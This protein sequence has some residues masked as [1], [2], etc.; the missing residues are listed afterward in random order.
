MTAP[1]F[2]AEQFD[3]IPSY[4]EDILWSPSAPNVSIE[5][6]KPEDLER[7]VTRLEQMIPRLVEVI[8]NSGRKTAD[9][10][11]DLIEINQR[12]TYRNL[13]TNGDF[14][15]PKWSGLGVPPGWTAAGGATITKNSSV[16]VGS[17]GCSAFMGAVG[18]NIGMYQDIPIAAGR[19]Y[20]LDLKWRAPTA[21]NKPRVRVLTDGAT[22]VDFTM[23]LTTR[24]N[25]NDIWDE[26]PLN[27]EQI[28]FEAPTDATS[29][30][31]HLLS[32]TAGLM[33]M[34]FTD[35][36]LWEGTL[37]HPYSRQVLDESTLVIS[38]TAS[39][40]TLQR[41]L[42]T[43]GVGTTSTGV[44]FPT[45]FTNVPQINVTMERTGSLQS[46]QI[47]SV[48][49]AGFTVSRSAAAGVATIH[50]QAVGVI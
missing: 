2:N 22:P 12:D 4:D 15:D 49:A 14:S 46:L 44:T 30:R 31:V 25:Q 27:P 16:P 19:S 41:G 8:T 35:I 47:S 45:A 10:L 37:S 13:V 29:V 34:Y 23:D 5:P 18:A 42:A 33:L 36:G 48:T 26:T 50:W 40:E 7:R 24:P 20:T 21:A 9:A 11:L 32:S 39:G 43:M 1:N 28:T 38:G 6:P 17:K 3:V